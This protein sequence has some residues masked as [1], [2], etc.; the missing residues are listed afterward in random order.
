MYRLGDHLYDGGAQNLLIVVFV[1]ILV[2]ILANACSGILRDRSR[3]NRL[4]NLTKGSNIK[5][6]YRN[7]KI[8]HEHH[9]GNNKSLAEYIMKDIMLSNENATSL[10]LKVLCLKDE[11]KYTI[12]L[13]KISSFDS[14]KVELG[15]LLD[16]TLDDINY[17]YK[18]LYGLHYNNL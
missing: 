5:H 18:V 13:D 3:K 10:V 14:L 17:S 7:Y 1:V 8:I 11:V 12:P 16:T 15:G 6:S 4:K 2:T 9:F